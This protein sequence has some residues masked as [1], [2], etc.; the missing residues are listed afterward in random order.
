LILIP[1]VYSLV[2][3]RIRRRPRF[4]EAREVVQE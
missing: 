1:V 2:E 4:Y 3:E